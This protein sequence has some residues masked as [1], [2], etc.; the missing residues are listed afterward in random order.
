MSEIKVFRAIK[1]V[2]RKGIFLTT[3]VIICLSFLTVGV[4]AQLS[5]ANVL[6]LDLVAHLNFIPMAMVILA[7]IGYGLGFGVIPSLLAAE[8][9]SIPVNIRLFKNHLIIKQKAMVCSRSTVVG[10]LMALEMSS[11]FLLS[12][13]KPFLINHL[14]IDGLFLLFA[15]ILLLVILLTHTALPKQ[16]LTKGK[17]SKAVLEYCPKEVGNICHK[18]NSIPV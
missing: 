7:Y 2:F 8:S 14:G 3:A 11:T 1:S 16:S 15:G 9:I 12:K 10:V 6:P 18:K 13:L 17:I 4:F 5:H